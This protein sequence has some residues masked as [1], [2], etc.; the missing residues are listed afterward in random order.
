MP[1]ST[2]QDHKPKRTTKKR[3]ETPTSQPIPQ[4][5]DP[6]SKYAP[7]AWLSGGIGGMED[8]TVPSGQTCLVR[9]PGMEGL[10]KAGI[11]HNV[12]SLS[13]IVNEKHLKRVDGKATQEIDMGSL[14]Q[15][16]SGMDEVMLVVDK[17]I[18]HCVVKP[19][20]HRTPNDVTSRR[21]GVVYANMVDLVDKMFL[22]NFVVGG[23]RDLE[24]FRGGLDS[25]VGSMEDGEGVH[26]E[27]V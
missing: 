2:P 9:R 18:C 15:D 23:T 10:M 3:P 17:V 20:V 5:E 26:D 16:S 27:A 6:T 1:S 22:F 8:V 4:Q 11:L 21:P 19:E 7:N 13:Q 14:M 12:D 24:R 25:V